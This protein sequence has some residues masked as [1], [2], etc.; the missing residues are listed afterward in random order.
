[1][2]ISCD[3]LNNQGEVIIIEKNEG[4]KHLRKKFLLEKLLTTLSL[5]IIYFTGFI[6][7]KMK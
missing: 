3:T 5:K 2:L 4:I 1:M 7:N 6:I